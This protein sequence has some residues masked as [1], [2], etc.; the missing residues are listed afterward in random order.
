MESRADFDNVLDNLEK[1]QDNFLDFDF[2]YTKVDHYLYLVIVGSY[3]RDHCN[4]VP[5]SGDT[6][7]FKTD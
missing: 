6:R 5:W 3:Y 7:D 2:H 4:T 1:I